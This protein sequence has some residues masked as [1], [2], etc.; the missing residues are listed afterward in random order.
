MISL[1]LSVAG[2]HKSY[3]G[4]LAGQR[5]NSSLACAHLAANTNSEAALLSNEPEEVQLFE[6]NN[7]VEITAEPL[8]VV[9][10]SGGGI[11]AG[12]DVGIGDEEQVVAREQR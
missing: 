8:A 6:A 4:I 12:A 9:L 5:T 10:R 3:S 1:N 7:S 11:E 2:H